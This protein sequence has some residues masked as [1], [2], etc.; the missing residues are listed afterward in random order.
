[1]EVTLAED[2]ILIFGGL[3]PFL[4]E[5]L[6]QIPEAADPNG[7]TDALQRLLPPPTRSEDTEQE[8]LEDWENYVRPGLE[9]AFKEAIGI[10]ERDLH[11][12]QSP[13]N[14]TDKAATC[15]LCIQP[16]HAD[17][18][19]HA[20]NQARIVLAERHRFTEKELEADLV[21]TFESRR[22]LALVQMNFYAMLQEILLRWSLGELPDDAEE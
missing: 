14:K 22:E 16:N 2:G 20:L 11:S 6:R 3:D 21:L 17:A 13:G 12:L 8:F 5:I 15:E 1:M 19:I 4:V 18:W 9:E 10:V 7:S